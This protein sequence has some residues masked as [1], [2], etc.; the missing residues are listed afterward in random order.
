LSA[1]G[2]CWR[3]HTRLPT[4]RPPSCRGSVASAGALRRPRLTPVGARMGMEQRYDLVCPAKTAWEL[5]KVPYSLATSVATSADQRRHRPSSAA[6]AQ[7]AHLHAQE[8][9][10][11]ARAGDA[12]QAGRGVQQVPGPLSVL[13]PA[14]GWRG[15]GHTFGVCVG[16][17]ALAY[18]AGSPSR[19]RPRSAHAARM[20]AARCAV[21]WP[22]AKLSASMMPSTSPS[23][24]RIGTH[25]SLWTSPSQV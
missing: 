7:R 22:G 8:R 16:Q 11:G 17:G 1:T 13:A 10:L 25:S 20:S 24:A 21:K 14:G 4:S 18:K 9:A 2:S 3:T 5:H 19:H 23:S 15:G 12:G 6:A